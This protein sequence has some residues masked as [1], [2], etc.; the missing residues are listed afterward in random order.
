M[1]VHLNGL[2][3]V[4]RKRYGNSK[5]NQKMTIILRKSQLNSQAAFIE[6]NAERALRGG[7]GSS[8]GEGQFQAR[9]KLRGRLRDF[10]VGPSNRLA[11]SVAKAVV[12]SP[13]RNSSPVFFHH[14]DEAKI[15]SPPLLSIK[16]PWWGHGIQ[17][18]DQEGDDCRHDE[19]RADHLVLPAVTPVGPYGKGDNRG[20]VGIGVDGVGDI[21]QKGAFKEEGLDIQL[22][23]DVKS[24]FPVDDVPGICEGSGG[25]FFNASPSKGVNKIDGKE[26][27]HFLAEITPI[28]Y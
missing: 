7:R 12:E 1:D 27:S 22:N 26:D 10:V 15:L 19:D 28:G 17:R 5:K 6:K 18:E 3:L 24:L 14:V 21:G 25:L 9:R 8:G 20:I 4:M 23:V 11:Y 2:V 13:D 16:V